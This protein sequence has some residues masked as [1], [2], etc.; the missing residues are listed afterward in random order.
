MPI[1]DGGRNRANLARSQASLEQSVAEYRASVL[2][3]FAEVEDR[4]AGLRVLSVQAQRQ[5]EARVASERA[6]QL[7]DSR[8]RNG[9]TSYFE[10]IDAQ[11]T[12]LAA[13]RAQMQIRGARAG[14]TV[15]LI[16][17]LGGSWDGALLPIARH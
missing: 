9:Y 11:R 4:L 13:R 7:A 15:A 3:A 16:R 17:A 10:V 1:F 12:L 5:K 6:A 2:Q 8:Y 14:T